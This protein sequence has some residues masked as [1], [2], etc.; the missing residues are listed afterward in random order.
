MKGIVRRRGR[1]R[2]DLVEIVRHLARESGLRMARR[3]SAEADGT[4]RRLAAMPGLGTRYEPDHPAFGELRY[5]PISRFK[6]DVV[7]YRP[8]AGGI[9]VLRVLHGARDIQGILSV[10][11]GLAH[12]DDEEADDDRQ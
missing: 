6:N 7:F 9:E 2:Q 3:S 1:A 4:F 8:I 12:E 10:E 11:F 5:L